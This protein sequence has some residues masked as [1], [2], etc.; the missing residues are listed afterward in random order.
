MH[1][2]QQFC[3]VLQEKPHYT[4]ADVTPIHLP[5]GLITPDAAYACY[6]GPSSQTLALCETCSP[7]THLASPWYHA[8]KP[9]NTNA[10]QEQHRLEI[11]TCSTTTTRCAAPSSAAII[12]SAASTLRCPSNSKGRVTETAVKWPVSLK[13][14]TSDSNCIAA[15]E[16]HVGHLRVKGRADQAVETSKQL[17]RKTRLQCNH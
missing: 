11:L 13:D 5:Y 3:W 12:R 8:Q 4:S 15:R 7:I 1:S 6:T 17:T 9:H 14:F 16:S 10:W 2:K